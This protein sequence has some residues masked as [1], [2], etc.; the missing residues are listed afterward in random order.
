M[1]KVQGD[2]PSG[3]KIE[4]WPHIQK[5]ISVQDPD[6]FNQLQRA[7]QMIGG[8]L[9]V[10][11]QNPDSSNMEVENGMD[12][13]YQCED[14]N[15]QKKYNLRSR[16]VK[17]WNVDKSK[18][19]DVSF[20]R[21]EIDESN[22]NDVQENEDYVEIVQ[23]DVNCISGHPTNMFSFSGCQLSRFH[24]NQHQMHQMPN[25]QMQYNQFLLEQHLIHPQAYSKVTP[26]YFPHL[27]HATGNTSIDEKSS[28]NY[29][30]NSVKY[31]IF[32]IFLFNL[33]DVI[34]NEKG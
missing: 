13:T 27:I 30:C 15:Q 6:D 14:Q 34:T 23:G 8:D 28:I 29:L 26:V 25:P 22:A 24:K 18:S 16:N 5:G 2:L 21:I 19:N 9:E 4:G 20:K 32:I 31:C 17:R 12:K 3:R 11:R 7:D 10:E 1:T 33:C